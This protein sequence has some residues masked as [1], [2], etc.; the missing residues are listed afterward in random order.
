MCKSYHHLAIDCPGNWGR[1]TLAQRTPRREEPVVEETPLRSEDEQ[2]IDNSDES[3]EE[4]TET[5][6]NSSEILS[7]DTVHEVDEEASIAEVSDDIQLF[8]SSES[9]TD[10]L[11]HQLKRR[12]ANE[13]HVKE[14]SR[15]EETPP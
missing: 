2:D 9:D 7:D 6:E 15:T 10:S 13:S 12:A 4:H 8:T 1:R 14:K 3:W 5:S 11:H